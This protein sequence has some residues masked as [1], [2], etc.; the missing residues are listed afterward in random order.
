MAQN[1]W[2]PSPYHTAVAA[3]N[4]TAW[5]QVAQA[6]GHGSLNS[7]AALNPNNSLG[8]IIKQYSPPVEW[9]INGKE[10]TLKEFATEI[11]GEGTPEQTLF[12]LKYVK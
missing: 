2:Y 4:N 10:M 1:P 7:P 12:I 8:N 6:Q 5:S 9:M 3:Q 11:Y